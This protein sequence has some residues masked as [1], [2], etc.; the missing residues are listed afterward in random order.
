MSPHSGLQP[1]DLQ[2]LHDT[3]GQAP[4]H[5]RCVALWSF[6]HGCALLSTP[7]PTGLGSAQSLVISLCRHMLQ[8][9]HV[10][11]QRLQSLRL[12]CPAQL[13][14]TEMV[15]GWAACM[16]EHVPSAGR[17][18]ICQPFGLSDQQRLGVW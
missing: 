15:A 10:N 17:Y 18:S 3:A 5:R 1:R 4:V 11:G 9:W 14:L 13:N 12:G 16:L 7:W 8:S 2:A 6:R